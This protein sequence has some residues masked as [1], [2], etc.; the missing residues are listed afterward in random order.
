MSVFR[1]LILLILPLNA[2]ILCFAQDS[3]TIPKKER[4]DNRALVVLPVVAS[5]PTNGFMYGVSGVA[6]WHMGN[7]ESS[8]LSNAVA[9]V[10]YTTKKQ[11]IN[12]LKSEIFLRNDSWVLKRDWRIFFT[13]AP[14]SD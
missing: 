5:N 2:Q 7:K 11:S 8:T 12:F 9:A 3:I 10:I 14:P 1:Q 6:G 4:K 13:A